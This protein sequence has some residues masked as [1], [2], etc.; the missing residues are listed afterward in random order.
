MKKCVRDLLKHLHPD[1][2]SSEQKNCGEEMYKQ[3]SQL[4]TELEQ[5]PGF[6]FDREC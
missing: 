1:K 5:R 6:N 4:K 2:L 3:V